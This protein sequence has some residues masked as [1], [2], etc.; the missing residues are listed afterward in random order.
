MQLK[1]PPITKV[2]LLLLQPSLRAFRAF[3]MFRNL[4]DLLRLNSC[5]MCVFLH[6]YKRVLVCNS[7]YVRVPVSK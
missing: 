1:S 7:F 3:K 5:T 2:I 4:I 6:F